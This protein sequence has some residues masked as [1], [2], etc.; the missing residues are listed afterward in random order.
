VYLKVHNF[1][2]Q[3]NKGFKSLRWLFL[4]ALCDFFN[5]MAGADFFW[6]RFSGQKPGAT[7]FNSSGQ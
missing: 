4:G 5:L 6:L 1:Y 2:N 7:G 3:R